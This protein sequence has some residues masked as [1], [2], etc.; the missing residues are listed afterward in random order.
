MSEKGTISVVGSQRQIAQAL[1]LSLGTVH[2]ALSGRG[3]VSAKTRE[4]ILEYTRRNHYAVNRVAASQLGKKTNMIGLVLPECNSGFF[5]LQAKGVVNA[6]EKAGYSVIQNSHNNASDMSIADRI[7]RL[8]EHRVDGLLLHPLAIQGEREALEGAIAERIPMVFIGGM[9]PDMHVPYVDVPNTLAAEKG[10]SSLIELGHERIGLIV[11]KMDSQVVS[12]RLSGSLQ[13]HEKGGLT[14]DPA[15][16]WYADARPA[17]LTPFEYFM[18]LKKP[19]TAIFAFYDGGALACYKDA[20]RLGIKIGLDIAI[21]GFGGTPED[22]VV[23]PTLSTVDQMPMEMGKMAF[24]TLLDMLKREDVD[25]DTDPDE[26]RY[27]VKSPFKVV[28]RD[29][30]GQSINKQ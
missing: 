10:V 13:A 2:R 1:G 6:A 25:N 22:E 15:L 5:G 24:E 21:M 4:R 29:S 8:R 20:Y 12:Q 27:W 14:I 7:Q 26:G 9:Q 16:M 3:S 17:D 18:Q 28:L 30:T 19:P 23:I 11:N